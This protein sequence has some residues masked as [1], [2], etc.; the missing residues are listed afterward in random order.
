MTKNFE[1]ISE[2][3]EEI[4]T[5]LENNKWD[6]LEKTEW[7]K[8]EIIKLIDDKSTS[9]EWLKNMIMSFEW[10]LDKYTEVVEDIDMIPWLMVQYSK[11]VKK[12][13]DQNNLD[14]KVTYI[15]MLMEDILSNMKR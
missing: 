13:W 14:Q 4:E 9:T 2:D 12:L 10:Y 1:E 7:H 11:I 15:T 6:M 8:D 3:I 5:I